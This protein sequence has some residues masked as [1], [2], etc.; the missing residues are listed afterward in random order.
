M[1]TRCPLLR[2]WPCGVC[3]S[4]KWLH[5]SFVDVILLPTIFA[6]LPGIGACLQCNYRSLRADRE[7]RKQGHILEFS[8]GTRRFFA[9]RNCKARTTSLD[10]YPTLACK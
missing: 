9:C 4:L 5:D 3:P 2:R 10:R 1:S 7:C 6:P 8:T